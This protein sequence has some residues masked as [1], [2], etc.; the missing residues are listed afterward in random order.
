MDVQNVFG[1]QNSSEYSYESI[2]KEV[3][4][5]NAATGLQPGSVILPPVMPLIGMYT[6]YA[7]AYHPEYW[8][9]HLR[10]ILRAVVVSR[11]ASAQDNLVNIMNDS[12]IIHDLMRSPDQCVLCGSSADHIGS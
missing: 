1:R 8:I 11:V 2:D 4:A 5:I 3:D 12:P 9:S 7:R 10:D 6:L